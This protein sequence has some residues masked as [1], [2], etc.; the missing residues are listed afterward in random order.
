M[1]ARGNGMIINVSSIAS[2][3]AGGSYSAAKAYVTVLSESLSQELAGTGVRVTAVCPGFVHTEFHSRAGIDMS[4]LPEW[5]WLDVPRVVDQAMRDLALNR[6]VSVAG[7]QYK[8]V[9]GLLRYGPRS[10]SRVATG[11]RRRSQKLGARD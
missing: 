7:V 4:G 5:L 1:V 8:A 6:S 9:S 10:L 3:M 2:W 11:V